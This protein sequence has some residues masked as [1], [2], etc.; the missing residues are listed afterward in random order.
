MGF[1]GFLVDFRWIIRGHVG[2]VSWE[3]SLGKQSRILISPAKMGCFR[4]PRKWGY[5]HLR[6][7][8]HLFGRMDFAEADVSQKLLSYVINHRWQLEISGTSGK[9]R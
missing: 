4:Q 7:G 1:P 5:N 8:N 2:S 6:R 9:C 3:I